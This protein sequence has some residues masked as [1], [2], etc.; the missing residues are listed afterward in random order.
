MQRTNHDKKVCC[1]VYNVDTITTN[2]F[3][4]QKPLIDPQSHGLFVNLLWSKV[5]KNGPLSEDKQVNGE[6]KGPNKNEDVLVK[7]SVI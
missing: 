3:K 1:N 4:M 7:V 5:L 6:N 2:S